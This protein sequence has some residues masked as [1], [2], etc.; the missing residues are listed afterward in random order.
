MPGTART[1][2]RDYRPMDGEPDHRPLPERE[3]TE[4]QLTAVFDAFATMLTDTQLEGDLEDLLWSA[5][6]LFHRKI[7]RIERDLDANE[8][9]QRKSQMLQ[10]GS[11]IKSVELERL[12][13]QGQR[14]L[15]RR[16]A[17]SPSA[18]M[19]RASSKRRPAPPGAHARDRWS[20]TGR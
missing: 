5:V 2:R 7:E 6:N 17:S 9:A 18:T 14:L 3:M 13:D 16:T 8:Q 4:A 19:P 11:E 1:S 10:D 15:D 20:A 12:L